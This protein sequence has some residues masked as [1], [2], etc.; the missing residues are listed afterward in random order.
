MNTED[1]ED[2]VSNAE[3]YFVQVL[4][5]GNHGIETMDQ[6]RYTMY[7]QRAG[8]T[9]QDLPPTS[10]ATQGHILLWAF[11]MT[12]TYINCLQNITLDHVDPLEY[13]FEF[14][15]RNIV[16]TKNYHPLPDNMAIKCNCQKCATSACPCREP[17]L[18]CCISAS[19]KQ[20]TNNLVRTQRA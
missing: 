5:C 17:G 4:N 10:N 7:H 3:N 6:L 11:Y 2:V 16:P 19:A 18:L 9:I 12:H 14:Q 1:I 20:M 8:T 15:D 13:G